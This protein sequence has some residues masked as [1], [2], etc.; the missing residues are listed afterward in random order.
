MS[1][2]TTRVWRVKIKPSRETKISAFFPGKITGMAD[3]SIEAIK[4]IE[5]RFGGWR[6]LK[7]E[8]VCG[9]ALIW[10]KEDKAE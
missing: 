2:I 8:E 10:E 5:K 4:L 6:V 7:I 3:T 9:R 1:T